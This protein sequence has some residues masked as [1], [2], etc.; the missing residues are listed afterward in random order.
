MVTRY[1]IRHTPY[2]SPFQD[3]LII[4]NHFQKWKSIA[5]L[6]IFNLKN[7]EIK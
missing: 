5:G 7:Q 1:A 4:A 2:F 3:T 6:K